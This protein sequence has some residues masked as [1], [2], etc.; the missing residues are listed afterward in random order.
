MSRGYSFQNEPFLTFHKSGEAIFTDWFV[1]N[2][3]LTVRVAQIARKGTVN[4]NAW[5][6]GKDNSLR[7]QE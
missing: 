5:F 7:L 2:S 4:Y 6:T 3:P 1:H